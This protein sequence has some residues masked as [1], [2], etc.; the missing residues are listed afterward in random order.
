MS[1]LHEVVKDDCKHWSLRHDF[2]KFRITEWIKYRWFVTYV[3]VE[4]VSIDQLTD[5]LICL[6]Y[7]TGVDPA[8]TSSNLSFCIVAD[9]VDII[10]DRSLVRYCSLP[11]KVVSRISDQDRINSRSGLSWDRRNFRHVTYDKR[12]DIYVK[13]MSPW[14]VLSNLSYSIST[15]QKYVMNVSYGKYVK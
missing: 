4:T 9:I 3:V 8:V 2:R 6:L 15:S 7:R 14:Y 5:T 10:S 1:T 13:Y 12:D 11:I